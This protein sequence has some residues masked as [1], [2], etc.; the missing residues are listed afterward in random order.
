MSTTGSKKRFRVALSYRSEKRDYVEK[1][2]A[3]LAQR[4]GEEAALYDRFH[5]AEF[6]RFNL[7]F[8]L[9]DHYREEKE[10]IEGDVGWN[11]S[12]RQ[13]LDSHRVRFRRA[14]GFAEEALDFIINYDIKYRMG[15][16]A[17][18]ERA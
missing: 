7:G 15:R 3:A 18:A 8:L 11:K 10:W 1:V 12:I 9:P 4:F 13:I 17:Q 5:T 16:D 14:L 6:E 2:A